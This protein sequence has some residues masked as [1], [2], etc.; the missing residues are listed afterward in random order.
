MLSEEKFGTLAPDPPWSPYITPSKEGGKGHEI[1]GAG[2]CM[3]PYGGYK[4][5]LV[6][7][8]DI[9]TRSSGTIAHYQVTQA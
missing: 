5:A 6:R 3:N 2:P 9:V 8:L 1:H 7:R 4:D